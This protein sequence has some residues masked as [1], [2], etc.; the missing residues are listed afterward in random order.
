MRFSNHKYAEHVLSKV[1]I[2]RNGRDV[3]RNQGIIYWRGS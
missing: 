3:W 2:V 1:E